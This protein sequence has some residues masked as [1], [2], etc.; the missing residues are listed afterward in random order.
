MRYYGGKGVQ[1]KQIS[2]VILDLIDDSD[3]Q[4]II[5]IEPFCG[6]LGVLR[7]VSGY[8]KKCYA[9]DLC[10]DLIM[11]LKLVKNGKFDN[12]KIT[13]DKWLK[14][15][16]TSKSSAERAFAGFGCSYGGVW[17]NGYISAPGNNDM[18]YSSLIRLAPKLQNTVFFNK[19]YIDF[20][21]EF[22]FDSKQKYVIYLDPPYKGTCNLP[23]EKSQS[24]DSAQ[25][26]NIVRKLGRMRN[27][28]VIVSEISAPSDFKCI[29]S[30]KRKNG[31]HN[32]T[33]KV[34]IEEKLYSI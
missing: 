16:Y 13:K 17:F 28:K 30:F 4:N 18:I 8:F 25:F 29:Y 34:V 22:P 7:H 11:L 15:K 24:F 27:V 2:A 32:I 26:W 23:W 20:L 19:N 1:G 9:N 6:A 3:R 33:D 31:M 12:P 10:K 5:Y 21:K 14:Y